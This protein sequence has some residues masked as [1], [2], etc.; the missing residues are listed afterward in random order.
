MNSA[1]EEALVILNTLISSKVNICLP[2]LNLRGPPLVFV[3]PVV[4]GNKKYPDIAPFASV[5]ILAVAL[6]KPEG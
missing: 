5:S 1:I 3:T 6:P 4:L 2:A